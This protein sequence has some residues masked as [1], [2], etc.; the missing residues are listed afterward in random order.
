MFPATF[1]DPYL[2]E[3]TEAVI[4]KLRAEQGSPLLFE[5]REYE[6]DLGNEAAVGSMISRAA[7]RPLLLV[8]VVGGLATEAD[9][10]GELTGER[11]RV[12]V[13]VV[14]SNPRSIIE[15]KR[16]A[17]G[18]VGYARKQLA[19]MRVGGEHFAESALYYESWETT[20]EE[21]G[22]CVLNAAFFLDTNVS[23]TNGA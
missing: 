13:F 6:G 4:E 1:I 19:G 11:I 5:V 17:M 3:I 10:T 20:A 9:A 21:A 2:A 12:E 8:R 15:Q 16:T 7:L 23:L 22:I 18:G 14:V